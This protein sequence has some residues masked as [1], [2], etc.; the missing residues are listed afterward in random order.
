MFAKLPE[1]EIF[2]GLGVWASVGFDNS[3]MHKVIGD[4]A[5]LCPNLKQLDHCNAD[6][7]TRDCK[8]IVIIREVVNDE[9]IVRYE[10][11]RPCSR[12]VF[13]LYD[14]VHTSCLPHICSKPFVGIDRLFL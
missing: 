6:D 9:R 8:R 7:K 10:V 14:A 5:G 4:L 1:L 12:W 11:R 2:R 3:R 13:F